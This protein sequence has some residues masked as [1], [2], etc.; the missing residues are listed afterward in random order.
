MSKKYKEKAKQV[1][2]VEVTNVSSQFVDVADMIT[3]ESIMVDVKLGQAVFKVA[4]QTITVKQGQ[5]VSIADGD[6]VV[7]DA[8]EFYA[9]YEPV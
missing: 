8:D 3:A 5:V 1:T 7:R 4:G 6:I 9:K 2:A